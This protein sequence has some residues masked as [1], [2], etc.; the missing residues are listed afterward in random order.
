MVL[1]SAN[2]CLQCGSSLETRDIDGIGRRACPNCDYVFWGDYSIGVG[3]LV[4]KDDKILLVKRAHHPGKGYWTNPGG[5]I[6]QL[7]S[8]EETIIREVE[9]ESGIVAQIKSIVAIRDL[10]RHVHNLYVAFAMDYI[11]GEPRP[12][13]IESDDAGFYSLKEIEL[14]N[15]ADFTKWLIQVAYQGATEGL[16]KDNDPLIPLKDNTLFRIR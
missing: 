4:I 8:I 1:L 9:E 11:S 6:E 2:F 15:V 13:G 5:Y 3:A 10:P 7:E 14:M 12:D 16:I